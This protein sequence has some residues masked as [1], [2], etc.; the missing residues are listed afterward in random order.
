MINNIVYILKYKKMRE[1]LKN[2]PNPYGN[3]LEPIYDKRQGKWKKERKKYGIMINN[4][5]LKPYTN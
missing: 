4:M 2:M 3:C 5:V 1:Y